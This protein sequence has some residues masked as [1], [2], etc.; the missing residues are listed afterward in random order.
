[1]T[2]DVVVPIYGNWKDTRTCLLALREQDYPHTV[3]VV[4]DASPDDTADRV[5]AEFPEVTLVVHETN[6]GFAT[7]CNSGIAAGTGDIVI[8]VNNDVEAEPGMLA[9]LTAAFDDPA[10]GSATPLLFRPDGSVDGFGI[11]ADV[12]VAGFV[13]GA[14]MSEAALGAASLP[15]LLGPYGA[16]AA[17]RRTALD[18]VG[19]LDEGIFMYGEELDLAL[20]LSLGGW[21]CVAVTASR[22]VHLGGAT[23]GRGSARQRQRAGFGRG[24]LLRAYGILRTRHALRA[25]LTEVIVSG[26]DLVL[27]RDFAAIRGR[28]EG[29]RAGAA[30]TPRAAAV[31]DLD[32]SIGFVDSLRM[33]V[34]DRNPA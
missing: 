21:G 3:F 23:A 14:G 29:W 24:Y 10:L 4:D 11:C 31:P 18:Q 6:R 22:G 28:R 13:R 16:V 34:A 2:V 33:R 8:L 17:Y 12:T 20:R 15:A 1:M 7:A 30:A 25:I 9:A 27:N 26:G 32:P 5:R 19:L